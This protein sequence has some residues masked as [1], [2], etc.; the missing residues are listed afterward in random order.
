MSETIK[1]FIKTFTSQEFIAIC[2]MIILILVIA[3]AINMSNNY[4]DLVQLYND[5]CV[6]D[7]PLKPLEII[8]NNS[9]S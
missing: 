6:F 8:F 2:V 4:N 9:F 3:L 1:E 7:E 5:N